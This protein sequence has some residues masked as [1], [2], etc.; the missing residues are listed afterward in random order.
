[1]SKTFDIVLERMAP[2]PGFPNWE[3]RAIL[4]RSEDGGNRTVYDIYMPDLADLAKVVHSGSAHHSGGNEM[5]PVTAN[6]S[7]DKGRARRTDSQIKRALA[8]MPSA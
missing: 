7:F 6:W 8:Q 2:Q 1:M 5:I 3:V 4:F